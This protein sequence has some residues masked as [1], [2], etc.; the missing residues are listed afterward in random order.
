MTNYYIKFAGILIALILIPTE[1]VIRNNVFELELKGIRKFQTF[2][3]DFGHSFQ[4]FFFWFAFIFTWLGRYLFIKWLAAF[5]YLVADPVLG[6]KSAI[7]LYVGAFI[8]AIIKLFYKVPR[9]YWIDGQVRGKMCLMDF[10]GP[11]DNQFFMAFFYSYNI[12]MFF[13]IY[14]KVNHRI[15]A[16]VLLTLL[17]VVILIQAVLLNYLGTVFYL[18]SLIGVVYGV[19]FTAI[20]LSLDSEIHRTSELTAFIIKTSKKYKFYFLF[21]SL[22]AFTAAVIYYNSEL[23]T[24]RVPQVWIINSQEEWDFM[25][26]FEI[27]LGLDETFK[28]T[29]SIFGLIGV[30]F[31]APLATKIIDNVAWTHTAWWKR[32]LRGLIGVAL[33]VGIFVSF[34]FI[35]RVDL[36]TAYFF[37]R[38][39]P[40]LVATFVLYGFV[41]IIWKYL[42]LIQTVAKPENSA[43]DNMGNE[44]DHKGKLRTLTTLEKDSPEEEEE[45]ESKEERKE[46]LLSRSVN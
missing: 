38:I 19:I 10:S 45:K 27:R 20:W 15:L 2:I 32:L 8:I 9:P 11:S 1:I 6:F 17:G 7:T 25:E 42:G 18:E 46:P 40:H 43:Y 37:N 24:W 29:A 26:N 44:D 41:P 28:G 36:P 39:L 34:G 22:I 33:Y 31:G 5:L 21:F 12:I 4:R 13:I 35:P 30:A 3:D 23:I 14:S 16:G